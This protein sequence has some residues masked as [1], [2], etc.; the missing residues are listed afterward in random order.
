[1]SLSPCCATGF[2][3]E[4]TP[5]GKE[6]TLSSNKAYVTG[7]NKEAAV[8]IVHDIFGWTLTNARML[9]DHYAEEADVT[10]YLPV[11]R[12]RG[13]LRCFRSTHAVRF[14]TGRIDRI[15]TRERAFALDE[16]AHTNLSLR[17]SFAGEIV[18]PNRLDPAYAGE[19]FD[20]GDF[21]TRNNKD[22]R[23]PEISSCA[24]ALKTEL[25]YKKVGAI[26]FCYGGWAVLKPGAKENAFVDC[27]STAHPALMENADIDA[28]GCPV[29]FLAPEEDNTFTPEMKEY[30]LKTLPTLGIDFDYQ[31]FAGLKHGFATRG[32]VNDPKQKHG[33]ERAKN[34]AEHLSTLPSLRRHFSLLARWSIFM[35]AIFRLLLKHLLHLVEELRRLQWML[36]RHIVKRRR[37]DVVR[38]A[39]A[40]KGVVLEQVLYFRRVEG[41]LFLEDG[42]G[43]VS[44]KK[45]STCVHGRRKKRVWGKGGVE[46]CRDVLGNVF[47]LEL[48]VQSF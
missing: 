42:V 33:L 32:D 8:L 25:G 46:V 24:K 31:Y 13:N 6:T 3:W 17:G 37:G 4:G 11:L 22:T 21:I 16:Y 45:R 20:I 44:G 48:H 40:D 9:A 12:P 18:A 30:T 2:R 23:W 5:K 15:R 41:R 29:Q 47:E 36:T 35:M 26:G 7:T 19:P 38:L 27:V 1:M 10:V 34:A 14:S 39:V 43:F 28:I